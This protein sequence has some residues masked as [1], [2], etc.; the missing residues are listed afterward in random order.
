MWVFLVAG[1]VSGVE[2]ICAD[3]SDSWFADP[4]E[5]GEEGKENTQLLFQTDSETAH[6]VVLA[7]SGWRWIM[8]RWGSGG[9]SF[10]VGVFREGL[11]KVKR[12]VWKYHGIR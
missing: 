3:F 11:E 2:S 4:G 6:P 12:I 9:R 1:M 8:N 5:V 10:E 7:R